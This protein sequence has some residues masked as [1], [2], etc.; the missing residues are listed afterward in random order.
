MVSHYPFD[1]YIRQ[2]VDLFTALRSVRHEVDAS[3]KAVSV[4]KWLPSSVCNNSYQLRIQ[5]TCCKV[6]IPV[7][8]P[9]VDGSRP[10]TITNK[11]IDRKINENES[12]SFCW[13]QYI[14]HACAYLFSLVFRLQTTGWHEGLLCASALSPGQVCSEWAEW[15]LFVIHSLWWI[16][17]WYT[18]R[19]QQHWR[20][21]MPKL[22]ESG[23]K[24]WHS[25]LK[26]PHDTVFPAGEKKNCNSRYKPFGPTANTH[27]GVWST[28]YTQ[29]TTQNGVRSQ[30]VYFTTSQLCN[31][32][33]YLSY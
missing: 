24:K 29:T 7:L 25:H 1:N 5:S 13:P 15:T 20:A 12:R 17:G 31:V 6:L 21:S 9:R 28:N 14:F 16:Q 4:Q 3:A 11:S 23:S 8:N 27:W 22:F 19:V 26:E 32:Y 18:R 33:I 30:K 10:R 2:L